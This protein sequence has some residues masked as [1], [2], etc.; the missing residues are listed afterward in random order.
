MKRKNKYC[1]SCESRNPVHDLA[2]HP[3]LPRI[4]LEP[5]S[6]KIFDPI[7]VFF[8]CITFRFRRPAA[9]GLLNLHAVRSKNPQN[10]SKA[11]F[12]IGTAHDRQ[13][14]EAR[15]PRMT[16]RGGAC[17]PAEDHPKSEIPH[18]GAG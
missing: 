3:G 5:I 13:I 12:E 18:P 17:P 11:I 14:L 15:R 16:V 10:G 4:R 2:R 6:K 8:G 7:V 1:H 9:A